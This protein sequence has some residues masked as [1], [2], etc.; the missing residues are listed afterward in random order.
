MLFRQSLVKEAIARGSTIG[1]I[2]RSSI[3]PNNKS[4][5]GSRKQP[6]IVAN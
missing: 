2:E 6:N 1:T 4:N 5:E 3:F